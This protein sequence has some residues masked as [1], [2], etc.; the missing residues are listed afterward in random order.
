MNISTE[1]KELND[2]H[3]SGALTQSEFAEAKANLLSQKGPITSQEH[4]VT[5][6]LTKTQHKIE[7]VRAS[8]LVVGGIALMMFSELFYKYIAMVTAPIGLGVFIY[9]TFRYIRVKGR[10]WIDNK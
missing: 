10:I 8:L 6:Q 9:G 7:K 3:K 2:L 1:L 5:I 4:V